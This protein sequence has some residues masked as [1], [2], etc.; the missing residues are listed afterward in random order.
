MMFDPDQSDQLSMLGSDNG[1]VSGVETNIILTP[2]LE[3]D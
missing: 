1:S 2:V 3:I